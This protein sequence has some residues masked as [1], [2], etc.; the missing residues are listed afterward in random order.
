[1]A[2]LVCAC[3]V[4]FGVDITYGEIKW[5]MHYDQDYS[6]AYN[7]AKV[8]D[9]Y[10]DCGSRLPTERMARY[11]CVNSPIIAGD[12]VIVSPMFSKYVMSLKIENGEINWP[13]ELD[14]FDYIA[15]VDIANDTLYVVHN[16]VCEYSLSTNKIKERTP[17][18]ALDKKR[19]RILSSDPAGRP[20]MTKDAIYISTSRRLFRYD[21]KTRK[22]EKVLEWADYK[23]QPG[24]LMCTRDRLFVVNLE[25]I[26]ALG[27]G[28]PTP[29]GEDATPI[30]ISSER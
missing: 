26:V 6:K 4:I 14:L 28:K 21:R 10:K 9:K 15:G 5:A 29:A 8:P 3:G 2:I 25:E 24:N 18:P 30:R 17:I 23:M 19:A 16:D 11:W 20:A 27:K 22:I 1:M 7:A 12:N 13:L